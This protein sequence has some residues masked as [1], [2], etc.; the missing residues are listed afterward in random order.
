MVH[1]DAAVGLF[2]AFPFVVS[3]ANVFATHLD[4]AVPGAC[5]VLVALLA[6]ATDGFAECARVARRLLPRA[7]P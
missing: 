5:L 3:Y 6:I 2:I 7:Y 4:R 1:P